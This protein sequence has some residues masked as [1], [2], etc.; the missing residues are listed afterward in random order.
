MKFHTTLRIEQRNLTVADADEI[1]EMIRELGFPG[2][3]WTRD[4]DDLK[5]ECEFQGESLSEIAERYNE[6]RDQ[7]TST[8]GYYSNSWTADPD[9]PIEIATRAAR[10][11]LAWEKH[12]DGI[13]LPDK[14]RESLEAVAGEDWTP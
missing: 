4:G 7:I 5:W 12:F 8:Y 11:V 1:T 6:T 13:D 9:D 14:L 2:D 10:D 3:G